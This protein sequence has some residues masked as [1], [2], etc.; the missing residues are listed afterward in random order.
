MT[1]G[2]VFGDRTAQADFYVVGMRTKDQKVNVLHNA[3]FTLPRRVPSGREGNGA[4][5]ETPSDIDPQHTRRASQLH[6]QAKTRIQMHGG[7]IHEC[8][9][10][11]LRQRMSGD[12]AAVLERRI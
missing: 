7:R 10:P 6:P 4:V 5:A 11:D 9:K 12:S 1:G 8:G 3:V 2:R